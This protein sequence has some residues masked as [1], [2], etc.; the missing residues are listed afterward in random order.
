MRCLPNLGVQMFITANI[1]YRECIIEADLLADN[2]S[3][4][5]NLALP[6]GYAL[7]ASEKPGYIVDE[8]MINNDWTETSWSDKSILVHCRDMFAICDKF[9]TYMQCNNILRPLFLSNLPCKY[10]EFI[11]LKYLY[12]I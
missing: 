3:E 11:Y 10:P 2:I 5:D 8:V 7:F 4:N 9:S 1:F 12:E 6:L